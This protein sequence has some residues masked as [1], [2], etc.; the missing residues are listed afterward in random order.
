[1]QADRR[2]AQ[3]GQQAG[4]ADGQTDSADGR[5]GG[6]R[7]GRPQSLADGRIPAVVGVADEASQGR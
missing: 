7:A 2:T 1:M 4:S 3:A 6:Q 5:V